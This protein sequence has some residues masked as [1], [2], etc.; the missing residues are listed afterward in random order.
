M[1][2]D[3]EMLKAACE[4]ARAGGS[5]GGA[6]AFQSPRLLLL[7]PVE[8]L[9]PH[10]LTAG[11]ACTVWM[12]HMPLFKLSPMPACHA[13][14]PDACLSFPEGCYTQAYLQVSVSYDSCEH[15]TTVLSTA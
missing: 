7:R 14:A 10:P 1:Q 4:A 15:I 3:F 9:Q 13:S 6:H 2:V 8:P 5:I 11:H 12:V